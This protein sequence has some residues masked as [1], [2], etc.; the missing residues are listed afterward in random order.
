MVSFFENAVV[1]VN[2][3]RY[4]QMITDNF[5]CELNNINLDNMRHG[6]RPTFANEP[7]RVDTCGVS[8]NGHFNYGFYYRLKNRVI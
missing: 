5:W 6:G 3:I 7:K 8:R 1:Y 4:L 2:S